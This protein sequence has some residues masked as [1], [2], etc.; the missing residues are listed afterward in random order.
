V[1][2]QA[3]PAGPFLEAVNRWHGTVLYAAPFQHALFAADRSGVAL[4]SLRLAVSTT[5][6]LPREV[7]ERFRVRFGKPLVQALGI[8]EVGLVSINLDDPIGRWDS[9]GRPLADHRVRVLD[10]DENGLGEIAV[11]GAGMFDAYAV[12]WLAREGAAADGWFRTG[13][14]GRLDQEGF[15]YLAGRKTAVMNLAGRKVFPE[16]I[17]EVLNRHPAVSASRAYGR[18]HA[19]LGQ[20]VE[21]DVVLAQP[22][23]DPRAILDFCRSHLASFKVPTRLQV[24]STLPRTAATGKIRR[25]TDL[26]ETVGTHG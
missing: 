3:V 18:P 26:A 19:R 9:V 10:P 24:V 17:E 11:S 7:A 14:I 8:I 1:L 25:V 22:E 21:A 20:V 2:T 23:T 16:E 15:L 4:P 12:P 5:C 13:D 6:P